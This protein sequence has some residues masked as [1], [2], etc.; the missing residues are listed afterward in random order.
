LE[1][2][3]VNLSILP[4]LLGMTKAQLKKE[5]LKFL[6]EPKNKVFPAR[7]HTK[8]FIEA[9]TLDHIEDKFFSDLDCS[10]LLKLLL[11]KKKI[12]LTNFL[13]KFLEISD[14]EIESL[15]DAKLLK[16]IKAKVK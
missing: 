9:I 1:N 5:I 7:K 16:A 14:E 6:K 12:N 11:K 3:F 15:F 2:Y 10:K 4:N 8:F 13:N